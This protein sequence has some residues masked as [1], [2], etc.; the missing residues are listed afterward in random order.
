MEK[1]RKKGDVRADVRTRTEKGTREE[2]QEEG[3]NMVCGKRG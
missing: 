3:E 2:K 1:W